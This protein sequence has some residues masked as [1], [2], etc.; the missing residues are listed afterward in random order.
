MNSESEI[1]HITSRVLKELS[2]NQSKTSS[3]PHPKMDGKVTQVIGMIVEE[4][5][6][7]SLRA[8]VQRMLTRESS[9]VKAADISNYVK[10]NYGISNKCINK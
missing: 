9:E 5:I 6:D 10:S 1:V 8:G 4:C 7:N 2:S 3:M